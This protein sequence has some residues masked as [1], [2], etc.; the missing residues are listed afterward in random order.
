MFAC[1]RVKFKN[2]SSLRSLIVL[3]FAIAV[4]PFVWGVA[5]AV[6]AM[7]ETAEL[8]RAMNYHAYEQT[9]AIRLVSQ[10][11]SD[12]ERKARLFV[13]LAAPSLRQ[14]YERTSYESTRGSFKQALDELLKSHV[15][16]KIALLV[17]ELAEKEKLIYQ[18]IIGAETANN[19][20]LPL[21]QAFQGLREASNTLSREF[22]GHVG[23]A[24]DELRQ[25]SEAI[26]NGL[27]IKEAML[28][29]VSF[30]F[31]TILLAVLSR[32]MRQLDTF[33]RRLGSGNFTAPI[34]VT[35][36]SD[37]RYLGN[38][39]E[40]LRTHLLELEASKQQVIHNIVREIETPLEDIQK[41]AGLLADEKNPAWQD[42]AQT[43][44]ANIEKLKIVSEELIRYSQFNAKPEMKLKQTVDLNDL[45]ESVLE[46]AKPNLQAKS[47][48]LKN[49]A[50]P[51][52]VFGVPEHLRSIIAQLVSNAVTFSPVGGEI[53]I[54]LRASGTQMEFE[55]ED[56][57]PGIDPDDRPHVFEPFFRGKAG[58]TGLG[59][60]IVREYVIHHQGKVD[61][62]DS[63]QGQHG[64]RI[65]VH[66]PLTEET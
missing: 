49:F 6:F 59:L 27:L 18:Q 12:V 43:L 39:L 40:W 36:P 25:K 64:T 19:I 28:S 10:K 54:V 55:V 11:A 50:K 57:G 4:I 7:R 24:F 51:V 30:M 31:I 58:G 23:Q 20:K 1:K 22:E 47:I 63:R 42:A 16:N 45:L 44:C 14:P 13:L 35:G 65:R 48:T 8:G 38:R 61:I 56:E 37:L 34:A 33:I 17:N 62:V 41:A 5:G 60:A 3:G 53:R 9:K 15:D 2:S 26:E 46:D 21:D 32:S 29:L 52:E 66:L